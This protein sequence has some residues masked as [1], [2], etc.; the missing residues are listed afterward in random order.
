M[1]VAELIARIEM[2]G[3]ALINYG[4]FPM[5]YYYISLWISTSKFVNEN[6]KQNKKNKVT[7]NDQH[8]WMCKCETL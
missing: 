8:D 1:C 4:M 3:I 5:C 7:I 2:Y 6:E